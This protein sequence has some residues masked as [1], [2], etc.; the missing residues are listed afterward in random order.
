MHE[1]IPDLTGGR[2]KEVTDFGV[3]RVWETDL[4]S[5]W[6]SAQHLRLNMIQSEIC[7]FEDMV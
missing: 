7:H 5:R 6:L 1:C 2:G 4:Q 3:D